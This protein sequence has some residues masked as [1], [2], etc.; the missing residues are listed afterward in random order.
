MPHDTFYPTT[1]Q[2]S[3]PSDASH[4]GHIADSRQLVR[5]P[6]QSFGKTK[7]GNHLIQGEN[8]LVLK[9]L[10]RNYKGKVRCIYI[11]PPYNNQER[12]LHYEDALDHETW[13]DNLTIR[14]RLLRELL[15]KDGSI[16]ISIDDKELHYLKVAADEVFGRENFVHTI[17]W[18][19]RTTRENR[20]V[21]SNNHEYILVYAKDA[22]SFKKTRNG[23]PLTAAI[24]ERYKNPDGDKR[25]PWQSISANVQDG[26]ATAAQFYEVKSPSGKRHTPPPGRCWVYS[27]AR[28]QEEIEKNNIWFG[29]NGNGV[30]RI[31]K[32]L[33]A[34]SDAITPETLWLAEDVGTNDAAK[35]HVLQLFPRM[36]VFDTP[37]PESLIKRVISLATNPGELVVDAYGGCGTTAAVAHKLDRRYI[38]IEQGAH[39]VTH[40]AKRLRHVIEGEQGGISKDINWKGGGGFDFY[41]LG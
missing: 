22:C 32:F 8:S 34:S 17:V 9:S 24:K 33:K 3:F 25:G 15:R 21:F 1:R 4:D 35:K 30:P 29:S 40:C 5:V 36:K 28:M 20:K 26:H 38:V 27:S 12:H 41:R 23:L 19:Q 18:Q 16:W 39:A 13:I 6:A 31:K 11:D 14:L 10:L 7:T 37:K 2:R